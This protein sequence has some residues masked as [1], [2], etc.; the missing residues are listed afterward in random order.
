[1]ER[2]WNPAGVVD[3]RSEQGPVICLDTPTLVSITF[4]DIIDLGPLGKGGPP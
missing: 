3:D 4:F 1:M 2:P